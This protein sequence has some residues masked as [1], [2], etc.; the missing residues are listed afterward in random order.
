MSTDRIIQWRLLIEE[1]GP[2]ILHSKGEKNIIADVLSR[3]DANFNEKLPVNPTNDNMAY[4]F[5]TK[6]D[7]KETDFPLS[8]ILISKYQRLDK[9]GRIRNMNKT[10]QNFNTKKV[11]GVELDYVSRGNNIPI[12][13]Q[14]R[15]K[16]W[17]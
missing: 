14:Q 13:L 11:E 15:V 4:I 5:L 2:I 6:K 1:F 8:P 10:N 3:L 16:T 17:Y 7:I 12:Q 9:E